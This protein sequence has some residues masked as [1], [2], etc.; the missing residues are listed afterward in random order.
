MFKSAPERTN[1]V[2]YYLKE[3]RMLFYK[4]L[5]YKKKIRK[6]LMFLLQS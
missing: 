3:R 2:R 6:G 1:N 5:F 4:M